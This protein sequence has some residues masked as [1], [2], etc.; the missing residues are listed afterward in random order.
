MYSFIVEAE[1]CP[2]CGHDTSKQD[3]IH[4]QVKDSET[5]TTASANAPYG[6]VTEDEM[7]KTDPSEEDCPDLILDTDH[8]A[9]TCVKCGESLPFHANQED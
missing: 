9:V 3:A 7:S 6:N 4:V 1:K 2:K 5:W 8:V